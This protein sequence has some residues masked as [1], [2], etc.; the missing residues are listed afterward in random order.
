MCREMTQQTMNEHVPGSKEPF[1][2]SAEQRELRC[3]GSFHSRAVC[4]CWEGG[5]VWPQHRCGPL[6]GGP[7]VS[8]MGSSPS[9]PQRC[10]TGL[11]KV[12]SLVTAGQ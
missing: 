5:G 7:V 3:P 1:T 9:H 2:A 12:H 10:V 8:E 4:S 6:E 11:G